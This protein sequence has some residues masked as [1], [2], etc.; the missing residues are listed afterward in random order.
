MTVNMLKYY[1]I[2]ILGISKK[3]ASPTQR[4]DMS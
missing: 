3:I 4:V 1:K 2:Q